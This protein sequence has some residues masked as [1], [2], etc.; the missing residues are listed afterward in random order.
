M[1]WFE[2]TIVF[3]SGLIIFMVILPIAIELLPD[4]QLYMGSTVTT[5]ISAMFVLILV[6]SF[7]IYFRQSQEP[8]MYGGDMGGQQY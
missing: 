7:F 1:G 6:S 2:G 5:L 3:V 4:I 8:D